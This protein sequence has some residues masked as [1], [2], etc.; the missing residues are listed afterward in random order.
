VIWCLSMIL[1]FSDIFLVKRAFPARFEEVRA[2]HPYL[3]TASGVI[4]VAASAF[5]AFIT[6][7][8]PWT[9]LFSNGSWRLWLGLLCG[10]SALAAVVIYALSE[11]A[12]RGKPAEA[13]E[14]LPDEIH[15]A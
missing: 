15:L 13:E 6:F 10:V 1:L 3:L 7:R 11:L 5:G 2:A 4:G 8:S 14:P 9:P 12:H